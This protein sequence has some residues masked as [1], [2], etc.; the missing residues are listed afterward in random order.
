MTGSRSTPGEA[1]LSA[2]PKRRSLGPRINA[3][4]FAQTAAVAP[5]ALPIPLW[6]AAPAVPKPAE[7]AFPAVTPRRPEASVLTTS[8]RSVA[9]QL[10]SVPTFQAG[11]TPTPTAVTLLPS[12][13]HASL[14]VPHSEGQ[15]RATEGGGHSDPRGDRCRPHQQLGLGREERDAGGQWGRASLWLAAAPVHPR[16]ASPLPAA[17]GPSV[18][19]PRGQASPR[20]RL[21]RPLGGPRACALPA[22]PPRPL[23]PTPVAPGALCPRPPRRC[24]SPWTPRSPT[25]GGHAGTQGRLLSLA[26]P[27]TQSARREAGLSSAG[28]MTE[29]AGSAR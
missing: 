13:L 15:A 9:W 5:A 26:A 14:L 28:G 6:A 4:A 21:A 24:P 11:W 20:P 19:R 23:P 1:G 18:P 7:P 2:C 3:W 22:R 27:W 16:W 29:A 25:G 17:A 12:A 8:A 10:D